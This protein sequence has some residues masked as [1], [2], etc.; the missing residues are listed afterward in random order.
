MSA[1]LDPKKRL[2]VV[3]DHPLFRAMLVQLITQELEMVVCGE[4]DN[5][6]DAMGLIEELRPDA[7]IVDLTL[8]GSG[9]LE[10]LKDVKARH[11]RLSVLVLSMHPESLYAERVLRAGARGYITKQESPAEVAN[12]IRTVLD[13][14]IHLS[15]QITA[16]LLER[17]RHA[18]AAFR[19]SGVDLLSDR[20][21]E[22][23]QLIGYGLNSREIAL[24]LDLV[25]TTVDSY[26]AR[27]KEKLGIRNAAMLYQRA[28]QWVVDQGV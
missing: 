18:D 13:G 2:L 16:T 27:I 10:L 15:K 11:I 7:A 20:E 22:V 9:G 19:P 1:S 6:R 25:T 28:A 21:I 3:E 8:A 17:L 12:A 4:T 24:R 26:R 23:Y 14:G 5:I